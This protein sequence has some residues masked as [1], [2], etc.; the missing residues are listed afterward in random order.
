[1]MNAPNAVPIAATAPDLISAVTDAVLEEVGEWHGDAHVPAGQ[2]ARDAK[3]T[4]CASHRRR[5]ELGPV[6]RHKLG[7]SGGWQCLGV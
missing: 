6:S 1:M 5:L 3:R 2:W 7:T 4:A